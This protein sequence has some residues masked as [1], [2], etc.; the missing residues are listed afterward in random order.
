MAS[1]GQWIFK[2]GY[3]NFTNEERNVSRPD[4]VVGMIRVYA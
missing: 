2:L 4:K 3:N 1:C